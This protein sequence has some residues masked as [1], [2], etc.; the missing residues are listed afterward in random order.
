MDFDIEALN[1]DIE[2][3]MDRAKAVAIK[4]KEIVSGRDVR[5]AMEYGCGTGLVSFNLIHDFE[6][7]I[8][9]D[10][11]TG[12]I[13][14]L[15][16]KINESGIKNMIPMRLDLT[17][18]SYTDKKPD[19][20]YAA[21]VLHHIK[22]IGQMIESFYTVLNPD[23][24]LCIIDLDKED[25]SFHAHEPNYDGHNGFSHEFI[26]EQFLCAGFFDVEVGTFYKDEV[27]RLEKKVPYSLFYATGV[28]K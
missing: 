10:S 27:I 7:I 28:K 11:S 25:G 16:N 4:I 6:E 2:R 18:D 12:M 23:G 24:I 26:K 13:D 14:V 22:N 1:W 19:I 17:E 15:N 5:T 8:L 3:R 21:M 9:A 20:I